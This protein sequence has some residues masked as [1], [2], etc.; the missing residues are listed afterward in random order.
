MWSLGHIVSES[1]PSLNLDRVA[2]LSTNQ[3]AMRFE[4]NPGCLVLPHS[5]LVTYL[6]VSSLTAF[7]QSCLHLGRPPIFGSVQIFVH[8]K[9]IQVKQSLTCCSP[10]ATL[11]SRHFPLSSMLNFC[12]QISFQPPGAW[13]TA[14]HQNAAC[15]SHWFLHIMHQWQFLSAC[16][17]SCF[18][19][20]TLCYPVTLSPVSVTFQAPFQSWF[21]N[22]L[23]LKRPNQQK[24]PEREKKP[25]TEH[26]MSLHPGSGNP[27]S[28]PLNSFPPYKDL[29]TTQNKHPKH[30]LTQF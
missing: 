24:K 18:P 5:D 4:R 8:T 17:P 14:L 13:P 6:E 2:H 16:E 11:P 10:Q 3:S 25:S 20:V 19:W 22:S 1:T 26:S 29:N 28:Y 9:I 15:L 21:C 23:Q 30:G 7:E 12:S 27:G